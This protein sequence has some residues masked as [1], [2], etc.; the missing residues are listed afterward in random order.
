MVNNVNSLP[1]KKNQLL[2]SNLFIF[3]YKKIDELLN[4]LEIIGF[5]G[6]LII[7]ISHYHLFNINEKWF[8]RF[9]ITLA[10]DA[11][12]SNVDYFKEKFPLYRKKIIIIPFQISQDYQNVNF[13]SN[14]NLRVFVTGTYHKVKNKFFGKQIDGF[15]TL[16]PHRLQFASLENLPSYVVNKL[17]LFDSS[18]NINPFALNQKKYFSFNMKDE[19]LESSH[20]FIGSEVT[21]CM[22]IGTIEAMACGCIIFITRLEYENFSKTGLNPDC[23]IFDDIN[24]LYNAI[25][26][27][28]SFQYQ[29]S[30]NNKKIASN[31]YGE[32]LF[33]NFLDC[34]N[35]F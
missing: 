1:L 29:S 22:G 6:R 26:D 28:K 10:F 34:T 15:S 23:I 17:S 21:G 16:H 32:K 8:N 25:K 2:N 18:S 9:D 33:L 24:D 4:H 12:V 30:V 20:A 19:L 14:R 13:N 35:E 5:N 7:H 31:Y 27:L 11:D 3:A